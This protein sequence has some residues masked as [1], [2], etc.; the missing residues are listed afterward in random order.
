LKKLNLPSHATVAAYLALFGVLAGGSAYAASKI[1]SDDIKKDAVLSKH[2]KA[3]QVK[4]S[5]IAGN[6]KSFQAVGLVLRESGGG[7]GFDSDELKER[8]FESVTNFTEGLYCV[9]PSGNLDP[10]KNPPV[11]TLEYNS[12]SG[13]NFTAMWDIANGSGCDPGEY[14]VQTF[15]AATGDPTDDVSFVI[16]VP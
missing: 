11:I 7:T 15:D 4:A 6:G 14:N 16:M 3:D 12:S 10:A 5:D 1:G 2:I 8:G 13:E 9:V